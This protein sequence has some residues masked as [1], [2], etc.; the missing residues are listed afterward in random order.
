MFQ[1]KICRG[2]QNTHFMFNAVFFFLN[3]NIYDILWK[4]IVE[5]G[6]SQYDACLLHAGYLR[7]EIHTQNVLIIAFSQQHWLHAT[8]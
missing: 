4:N 8:A 3:R 1:K 7:L 6:R 5:P 2:N